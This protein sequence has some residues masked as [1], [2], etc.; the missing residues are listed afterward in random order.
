MKIRP[1]RKEDWEAIRRIYKMGMDTGLATFETEVPDWKTWDA[2][3]LQQCRLVA[4]DEGKVVG[5]AVL[6][7]TSKRPAYRGVVEVSIYVDLNCTQKGIGYVLMNRLI[8]ESEQE[9]FWT[10]YSAIFLENKASIR[11]H[12]KAGFRKI[13]FRERIAKRDGKWINT[14]L[15]ERR[16]IVNG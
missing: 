1:L 8:H 16:S 14:L 10:L 15:M 5:W 11:L 4:E 2:K 6:S 12:E 9:G 7:A 3:F 13:G